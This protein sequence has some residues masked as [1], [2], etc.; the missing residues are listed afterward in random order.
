MY[1]QLNLGDFEGDKSFICEMFSDQRGLA[2]LSNI[3]TVINNNR[4]SVLRTTN[5]VIGK[6]RAKWFAYFITERRKL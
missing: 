1:F 5:L 4:T 3:L 2:E 6:G